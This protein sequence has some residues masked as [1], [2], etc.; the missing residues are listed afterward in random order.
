MKRARER[1]RGKATCHVDWLI[2]LDE[3]RNRLSFLSVSLFF[4]NRQT[5]KSKQEQKKKERDVIFAI[6]A[7]HQSND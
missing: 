4:E 1:E 5:F 3:Q 6:A 2:S 7:G